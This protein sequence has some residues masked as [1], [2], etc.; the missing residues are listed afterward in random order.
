V[1]RELFHDLVDDVLLG[2]GRAGSE[3]LEALEK[4]LHFLV[5]FFEQNDRISRH[6]ALPGFVL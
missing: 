4:L 6:E 3:T 5:I 2:F 1:Y